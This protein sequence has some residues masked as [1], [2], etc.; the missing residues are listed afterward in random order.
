MCIATRS[1]RHIQKDKSDV[2]QLHQRRVNFC[3]EKV[4]DVWSQGNSPGLTVV[5]LFL[6]L[7]LT[8]ESSWELIRICQRQ[9]SN[10]R[11]Y[12]LLCLR[13]S[14]SK[15][16]YLN[17]SNSPEIIKF[18][19]IKSFKFK[20]TTRNFKSGCSVSTQKDFVWDHLKI[21]KR[22]VNSARL[23]STSPARRPW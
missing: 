10:P 1:R 12:C 11:R 17:D 3:D 22:Q 18:C 15:K 9:Q 21:L 16:I 7:N 23:K 5:L 4:T 20:I 14:L 6:V 2:D 8:S 19:L 13:L